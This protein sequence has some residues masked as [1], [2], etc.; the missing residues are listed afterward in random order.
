MVFFANHTFHPL[1]ALSAARVARHARKESRNINSACRAPP[2]LLLCAPPL[3]KKEHDADSE[4]LQPHSTRRA[5]AQTET[6][7]QGPSASRRQ[8]K[9]QRRRSKCFSPSNGLSTNQEQNPSQQEPCGS[10]SSGMRTR[11]SVADAEQEQLEQED[12]HQCSVPS[13]RSA[14]RRLQLQQRYLEASPEAARGSAGPARTS[15]E[16][17]SGGSP[18][19]QQR[20]TQS[21][22]R[23]REGSSQTRVVLR[24]RRRRGGTRASA[25]YEM[26]SADHKQPLKPL[27]PS[28]ANLPKA[29]RPAYSFISFVH[30]KPRLSDDVRCDALYEDKEKDLLRLMSNARF[31]LLEPLLDFSGLGHPATDRPRRCGAFD[32]LGHELPSEDPVVYLSDPLGTISSFHSFSGTACLSQH[33]VSALCREAAGMHPLLQSPTAARLHFLFF[34]CILMRFA[35]FF[36]LRHNLHFSTTTQSATAAAGEHPPE[37]I[38]IRCVKA[39]KEYTLFYLLLKCLYARGSDSLSQ[40]RPFFPGAPADQQNIQ[41][42]ASREAVLAAEA[43]GLR[44]AAGIA[45]A[46]QMAATLSSQ[47]SSID[48]VSVLIFQKCALYHLVETLRSETWRRIDQCRES[49]AHAIAREAFSRSSDLSCSG[50]VTAAAKGRGS[51]EVPYA[52]V[53]LQPSHPEVA[54]L[55]QQE[56]HQDDWATPSQ[57]R[58]GQGRQ[59]QHQEDLREIQCQEAQQL[60]QSKESIRGLEL[61]QP[62]SPYSEGQA[63]CD[64]L[65]GANLLALLVNEALTAPPSDSTLLQ[66]HTAVPMGLR[67]GLAAPTSRQSSQGACKSPGELSGTV[68]FMVDGDS[69]EN[70][71]RGFL[72]PAVARGSKAA[73]NQ[74]TAPPA[75]LHW[76]REALILLRRVDDPQHVQLQRRKKTATAPAAA[77]AAASPNQKSG[78]APPSEDANA[79]APTSIVFGPGPPGSC[80]AAAHRSSRILYAQWVGP[81]GGPW[82]G[83]SDTWLYH[84]R[85]FLAGA[86]TAHS[87]IA[88]QMLE[89]HVGLV[90]FLQAT[91]QLTAAEQLLTDT[92][93]GTNLGKVEL[94]IGA[95]LLFAADTSVQVTQ[96]VLLRRRFNDVLALPPT[97]RHLLRE[98]VWSGKLL[99]L[100][101]HWAKEWPECLEN[102]ALQLRLHWSSSL[103]DSI[104]SAA[105]QWDNICAACRKGQEAL[106]QQDQGKS[107]RA[108]MLPCREADEANKEHGGIFTATGGT[109]D[110]AQYVSEVSSKMAAPQGV[111]PGTHSAETLWCDFC[112]LRAEM[113]VLVLLQHLRKSDKHLSAFDSILADPQT[114][115]ALTCAPG[116]FSRTLTI[117][118]A[119]ASYMDLQL[120]RR[121][122]LGIPQDTENDSDDSWMEGVARICSRL[123]STEN[124]LKSYAR[125][126]ALRLLPDCVT[127]SMN[128]VKV[129]THV[130]PFRRAPLHVRLERARAAASCPSAA[131]KAFLDGNNSSRSE[132][133]LSADVFSET[134]ADLCAVEVKTWDTLQRTFETRCP[135]PPEEQWRIRQALSDIA[136]ARK[137]MLVYKRWL[138]YQTNHPASEVGDASQSSAA[139][140]E[141][142]DCQQPQ[143]S[144]GCAAEAPGNPIRPPSNAKNHS[145][146]PGLHKINQ[147]SFEALVLTKNAW[148]MHLPAGALKGPS[149]TENCQPQLRQL[150]E[151]SRSADGLKIPQ[152][153]YGHLEVRFFAAEIFTCSALRGSCPFF[154]AAVAVTPFHYILLL[155]PR[156]SNSPGSSLPALRACSFKLVEAK[157]FACEYCADVQLDVQGSLSREEASVVVGGG[158]C[159]YDSHGA[160]TTQ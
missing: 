118:D 153:L 151:H 74:S 17:F 136:A 99:L 104:Q 95:A 97:L 50:Q 44:S 35:V 138:H 13:R 62:R 45:A 127:G 79:A 26:P 156:D 14:A 2:G 145:K 73:G 98:N 66:S 88:A 54:L 108:P 51:G 55:L 137:T 22:Q 106:L 125:L 60:T 154:S 83:R 63:H 111:S 128:E 53:Q 59:Q 120:R 5:M 105:R 19:S 36:R 61:K 90:A 16:D 149:L 152:Q 30:E 65:E 37:D 133:V 86:A 109:Y 147:S 46:A 1:L 107:P 64:Y 93:F 43:A 159:K 129:W 6:P 23:S 101:L 76:I 146:N 39:W 3:N 142:P 25:E 7:N 57:E 87:A 81:G 94:Q 144:T 113:L 112:P 70:D 34:S 96:Q 143:Q 38:L 67:G 28:S 123:P 124:F 56:D 114:A 58:N 158:S 20:S 131:F 4:S 117:E 80:P 150:S 160:T 9:R 33:Y 15:E 155:C 77:A 130:S 132:E 102:V 89:K 52:F 121:F 40:Q 92:C 115:K 85:K 10:P 78:A 68:D 47:T 139:N 103:R 31:A 12:Q 119:L 29:G 71:S 116:S 82:G 21:A 27:R 110:D 148:E 91:E 42:S 140:L 18:G 100:L 157:T 24:Q 134:A 69:G 8:P 126:L 75:R 48:E 141:A 72:A 49:S 11:S 135:V 122:A 84:R 41:S 32:K